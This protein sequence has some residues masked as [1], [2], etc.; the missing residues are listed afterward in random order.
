MT[1]EQCCLEYLSHHRPHNYVIVCVVMLHTVQAFVQYRDL[2]LTV[3]SSRATIKQSIMY[4]AITARACR[5][6][7]YILQP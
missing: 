1:G 7:F 2:F 4:T 5:K 3:P 6:Y